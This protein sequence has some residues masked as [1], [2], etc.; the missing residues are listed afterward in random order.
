MWTRVGV[1]ALASQHMEHS[2][3]CVCVC[4]HARI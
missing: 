4:V 1:F 3:V 2:D